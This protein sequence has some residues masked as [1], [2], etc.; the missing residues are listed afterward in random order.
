MV[1]Q[2]V[3][4]DQN[5]QSNVNLA[6]EIGSQHQGMEGQAKSFGE[7]NTKYDRVT[8]KQQADDATAKR[9]NHFGDEWICYMPIMRGGPL[10]QQGMG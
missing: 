4:T 1:T 5:L 6:R 10:L 2:N 8:T 3:S 7:A 9:K